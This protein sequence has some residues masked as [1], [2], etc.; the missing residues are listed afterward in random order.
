M[1][2]RQAL[3]RAHRVAARITE[4]TDIDAARYLARLLYHVTGHEDLVPLPGVCDTCTEAFAVGQALG[5][6]LES[7]TMRR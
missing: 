7:I 4:P 6:A 5:P 1:D 3:A 2:E